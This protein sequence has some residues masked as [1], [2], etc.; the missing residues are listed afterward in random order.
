MKFCCYCLVTA[1]LLGLATSCAAGELARMR[2]A[3]ALTFANIDLTDLDGIASQAVKF[4]VRSRLPGVKPSDI[5]ITL[6]TKDGH[7]ALPLDVDGSFTLPVTAALQKEDPWITANQPKGSMV[8]SATVS[9]FLGAIKPEFLDGEW[10]VE[11]ARIFPMHAALK[12]AENAAAIVAQDRSVTTTLPTP[13][14][15]TL[16]CDD[17]LANAWIV[18]GDKRHQIASPKIGQ[19]VLPYSRELIE[20]GAVIVV[21][22]VNGWQF[23][24]QVDRQTATT[25]AKA[26]EQSRTQEL[27]QVH[28]LIGPENSTSGR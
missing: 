26:R 25:P 10:R 9:I 7:Q 16:S 28:P 1:A 2:Y 19:F 11:Y 27:Q 20:R 12:R 8:M 3:M 17:K 4:S 6:E 23:E 13:R 15:V 22:P 5:R 21:H 14:S 18:V 24:Y